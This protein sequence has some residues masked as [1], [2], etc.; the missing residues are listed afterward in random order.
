MHS[1]A[2][3]DAMDGSP[4]VL[5]PQFPLLKTQGEDLTASQVLAGLNSSDCNAWANFLTWHLQNISCGQCIA[6]LL[7]QSKTRRALPCRGLLWM[8]RHPR[9]PRSSWDPQEAL[10]S[11]Q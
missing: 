6:S 11:Q 8:D 1:V 7:Q 3:K 10:P 5:G 2:G 4:Q 9:V